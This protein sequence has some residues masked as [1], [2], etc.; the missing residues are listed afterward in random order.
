MSRPACRAGGESW[1]RSASWAEYT[2]GNTKRSTERVSAS[3]NRGSSFLVRT[4]IIASWIPSLV[5]NNCRKSSKP[6]R[7]TSSS[8]GFPS[9]ER[10]QRQRSRSRL[11]IKR[12]I[13]PISH[14]RGLVS[15]GRY[16]L[17]V[18]HWSPYRIFCD[19]VSYVAARDAQHPRCLGLHSIRMFQCS[20]NKAFFEE[21][22]QFAEIDASWQGSKPIA[23]LHL[24]GFRC[25]VAS[26]VYGKFI[27]GNFLTVPQDVRPLQ[28]VPQLPYVSGK[29]VVRD[30]L[31][32]FR[33]HP[34]GP[35]L[36][37]LRN[38]G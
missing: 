9:S 17:G 33:A 30:L 23:H 5:I 3:R 21:G 26:I 32:S 28:E 1:K 12:R 13:P 18:I 37:V 36:Q 7:L 34:A 10:T 27:S 31:Q 2:A 38:L 16:S 4:M 22:E 11:A 15:Y 19:F 24:L 6:R 20:L 8:N 29:R 35:D 25:L 14:L